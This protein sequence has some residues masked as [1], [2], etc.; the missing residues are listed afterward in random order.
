MAELRSAG[1]DEFGAIV[2]GESA[3]VHARTRA[4]LHQADSIN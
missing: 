1:V 2:F 3:E 4:L